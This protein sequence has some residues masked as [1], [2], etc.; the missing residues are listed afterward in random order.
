[1]VDFSD[2]VDELERDEF[3]EARSHE[4]SKTS[5]DFSKAAGQAG[6][7]ING[8]AATAV[9]AL[10]AKDK[11]DPLIF[12]AVPWCLAIYAIGVAASAIMLYCSMMRAENWNFFWYHYSYTALESQAKVHEKKADYWDVRVQISF[13][14]VMVAFLIASMVLAVTMAFLR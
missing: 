13:C 10:L 6:L 14:V 5:Y 3:A 7:L 1:M 12:K 8:G 2:K 9:I 11:V 4:A